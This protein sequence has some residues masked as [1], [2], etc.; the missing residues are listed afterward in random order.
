MADDQAR[1]VLAFW[2]G[3]AD[4]A[5]DADR[6]ERREWFSKDAAFDAEIRTRF[7]PLIAQAVAG[8]LGDWC[9]TP[10]GS[11]ARVIVLDQFTRNAFRD[12]ADAFSGD[13]RARA[14]A[15]RA[16]ERGFDRMLAPLERRFLYM[17]FEHS[18]A[19]EDQSRSVTLFRQLAE[20][21][22]LHDPVAWAERH[23]EVIRRFGRFPHRNAV[24]GR[25]STPQELEFLS[26][27]GSRF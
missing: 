3:S 14:T 11:L 18:E 20:D 26:M 19:I 27:P 2:F 13:E 12:S 24:L 1:S 8:G 6:A 16:I 15:D 25:A 7:G 21:T 17:P 10:R 5:A 4:G 22:G 9:G 23:A